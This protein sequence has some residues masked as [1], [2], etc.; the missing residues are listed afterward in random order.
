MYYVK[1]YGVGMLYNIG[2]SII[3][4]FG[5]TGNPLCFNIGAKRQIHV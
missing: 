5:S 1:N 3:K 4:M 2:I